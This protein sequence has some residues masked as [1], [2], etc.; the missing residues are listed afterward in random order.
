MFDK[1]LAVAPDDPVTHVSRGHARKTGGNTEE[2]IAS[3][4]AALSARPSYC[5]ARYPIK[6]KDLPIQ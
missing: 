4:K 5:D 2:A 1:V 6:P 3:Y